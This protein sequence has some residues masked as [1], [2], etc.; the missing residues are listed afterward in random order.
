MK[1]RITL[2]VL[3]LIT[4]NI[5]LMF[6]LMAGSP[7]Y[8]RTVMADNPIAYWGFDDG[9]AKDLSGNDNHGQCEGAVVFGVES[10]HGN[11]AA[12]IDFDGV[13]AFIKVPSLGEFKQSSI[14]AWIKIEELNWRALKDSNYLTSIFSTNSFGAGNHHL[15]VQLNLSVEQA[16]AGGGPNA[17]VSQ[18]GALS[19]GNWVH[20][21]STYDSLNDGAGVIYINGK[22]VQSGNHSASPVAVFNVAQIGSWGGRRKFNGKMDEVAIY[23]TALTESQV[24][25]HYEAAKAPS[26]R[27][28]EADGGAYIVEGFKGIEGKVTAASGEELLGI[29]SFGNT[30]SNSFVS[31]TNS[32]ENVTNFD[33]DD[34]ISVNIK[35]VQK[36]PDTETRP[37]IETKAVALNRRVWLIGGSLLIGKITNIDSKIITLR[38][39]FSSMLIPRAAIAAIDFVGG[40][41]ESGMLDARPEGV[42]FFDGDFI[43]GQLEEMIGGAE[44]T[45]KQVAFGK[46]KVPLNKVR[47]VKFKE[48]KEMEVDG[49]EV[50]TR[51]GSLIYAQSIK[52][53]GLKLIIRD[54]SRYFLNVYAGEVLDLTREEA[55]TESSP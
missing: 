54:N 43:E 35:K 18:K 42:L 19:I 25:T 47:A 1:F 13:N 48:V 44:L 12:A 21:V 8:S 16:I 32:K 15:N 51:S 46:T 20:L 14:E 4:V 41:L 30:K 49:F 10:A 45:I 52:S 5:F 36:L 37:K 33:F 50:R 2:S 6:Q 55:P 9:T 24:R 40:T 38:N 31:V 27:G 53:K 34:F 22:K 23:G 29:L 11:L 28:H 17:I 3:T 7:V 26:I 39:D